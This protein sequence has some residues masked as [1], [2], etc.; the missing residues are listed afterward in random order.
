M[1]STGTYPSGSVLASEIA[2]QPALWPTTLERVQSA[3]G[4]LD[5][6]RLPVILTGAGTSAYAGSAISEAW[7]QSR[8]IPST[9]LLVA[10]ESAILAN[11]PALHE[12][13]WLISL[14]RSGDSPESAAVVEKLKRLFPA[15][16]HLAIVCNEAGRLAHTPGV[17][18]LCLD[19]RTN[20]RSLAM[21]GSFSNLALAGL[22]LSHAD[23]IV[24]H[25]PAICRR[26]AENLQTT[27]AV[28]EQIAHTCED[29]VV[30][31][32]SAMQALG[33]EAA[34]K[35]IELTAGRV[36]AMPESFLGF[37][38]GAVGFLRND[39]PVICFLS[40]DPHTRLYERDMLDDLRAKG[41]G[42][43]VIIGDH[44]LCEKERDW[45]IPAAAPELPDYLRTPF[46]VPFAQL[47]AYH[48]SVH[49]HVDPENPSPDGAI[50][51]VVRPFRLHEEPSVQNAL[52]AHPRP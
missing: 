1:V 46:E 2:Q 35:I 42:R 52:P 23:E 37:R 24:Q 40:S 34:L 47:L 18:V 49:A 28:A 27:N 12:G 25:L 3:R 20:D 10:S 13:G 48:L 50:T 29:R 14:A 44:A 7:P 17:E 19:P 8:A 41:L 33:K 4:A 31:L 6:A 36:M 38:H 39:T 11:V 16:K 45:F 26:V 51:R 5:F 15:V 32:S 43:L 21:T 9:D 22:C 30:I